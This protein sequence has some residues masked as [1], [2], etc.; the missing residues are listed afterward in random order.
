LVELLICNQQVGGSSP[1]DGS[2]LILFNMGKFNL[3]NLSLNDDESPKK[4]YEKQ[5]SK[6]PKLTDKTKKNKGK[7]K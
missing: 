5:E 2:N 1:S 3:N 6:K 4:R 7:G